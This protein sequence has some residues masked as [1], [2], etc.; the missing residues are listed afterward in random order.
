MIDEASDRPVARPLCCIHISNDQSGRNGADVLEHQLAKGGYR[1]ELCC[2][3]GGDSTSH[4]G[5]SNGQRVGLRERLEKKG[6]K[7]NTMILYGCVRHF[8]ELELKAAFGAG[9]PG[10]PAEN[11]L[12]ALRDVIHKDVPFWR[13][14][15]CDSGAK[16]G[17][18]DVFDRCLA[19]MP[20]PTSSKWECLDG[21]NSKFIQMYAQLLLPPSLRLPPP[22]HPPS[23]TSTPPLLLLIS[24]PHPSSAS[25]QV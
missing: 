11:F 9:W 22:V 5:G 25:H 15:W 10:T 2:G 14:V 3:A 8:K 24:P 21:A 19:S 20:A 7:P 4:A 13:G 18:G 17:P 23:L 12:Y 16:T 6:L 1:P